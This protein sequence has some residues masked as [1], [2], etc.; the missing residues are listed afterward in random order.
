MRGAT[1]ASNIG[2]TVGSDT[3]PIKIV[4][5]VATPVANDLV[6]TQGSQSINGALTLRGMSM[7]DVFYDNGNS[8]SAT[9]ITSKNTVTNYYSRIVITMQNSGTAQLL[10]QKFDNTGEYISGAV[11]ATL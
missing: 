11:I 6:S 10:I 8:Q 7:H 2:G 5:D 1:N 4:N 9:V 3:K